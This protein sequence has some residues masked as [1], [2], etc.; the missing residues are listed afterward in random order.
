MAGSIRHSTVAPRADRLLTIVDVAGRIGVHEQTVRSWIK[1][2]ELKAAEFGTR[3][4]YRITRTDDEDFLR[5]RTLTGAVATQLL[6]GASA[7]QD[8]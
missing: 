6:K 8:S 2:G 5:R 3:I 7:A 4:G 1:G